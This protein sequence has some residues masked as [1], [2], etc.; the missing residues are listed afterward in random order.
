MIWQAWVT[1]AVLAVSLFLLAREVFPPSVTVFGAVIV[2]LVSGVIGVDAAFQGLS[3]PAPLT[4][5]ALYVL[6]RA[7]DKTGALQPLVRWTLGSGRSERW[8]LARLLFPTAAASAFLNNTPIVSMLTPQVSEWASQRGQSPSRYLMPLS[9]AAIL[10]GMSSAIGTSTILVVSGLFEA[11]G[12][13]PL[14]MFEIT[15]LGFP[16]GVV[17]LL[18]LVGLSPRLIPDRRA[19]RQTLSPDAVREFV[20]RMIVEPGGPLEGRAVE[21]SGLRRL[22][23]VFLVEIERAADLITPVA[24]G[25]A[26]RGGDHLTFVGRVDR[27]VDL[28][29]IRGLTS[30]EERHIEAFD[31]E[32]HTFFE[33]VV[34]GASPLLGMTLRESRF[35]GRYQA[36]VVAIHRAGD[37]VREKLGEVAIRP[38]DTLLTLADSDFKDRWG[39]RNDFLLVSR[40]GARPPTATKKAWVV[41]AIGLSIV[42]GAALGLMPIL[43]L[44][45]LGGVAL[46]VTRVL[47]PGEARNA[48]DLDVILVIAGAFGLGA[49]L[50]VSGLAELLATIL[51]GF[52]G[53]TGAGGAL[54][55]LLVCT[56]ALSAV[57]TNYAAAVLVFPVALSTAESV[58]ADPRLFGMAVAIGA[59]STFLTPLY[60]TNLMVFGPGGYR[61]G[62]YARLGAPLVLSVVTL[63]VLL[64]TW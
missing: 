13:A 62:D 49:A 11:H 59:A 22:R 23:G 38:G 53:G 40:L 9:F 32:R 6:A 57:A 2:L 61:F 10:G 37:R 42:L 14:G 1:L 47:T 29:G 19:A 16:V 30:P 43:Q 31:V 8:T 48:V 41:G 21:E 56:I 50:E 35:R 15:K 3:N 4:V 52:L 25:T 36:A 64:V 5:A 54:L 20:V 27:V 33:A 51:V 45:L 28:H 26:L 58:G 18:L 46:I 12:L 17:G 44:A 24:P 55:G 39:D 34:G 63:T 7:V 60:Q